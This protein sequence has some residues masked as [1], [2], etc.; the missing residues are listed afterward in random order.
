M[1]GFENGVDRMR[2]GRGFAGVGGVEEAPA[3]ART[4]GEDVA[5]D[6]SGGDALALECVTR[7]QIAN[8]L[9]VA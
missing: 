8:D 4:G 7:G 9:V 6:F 1:I 3:P 5:F 2:V